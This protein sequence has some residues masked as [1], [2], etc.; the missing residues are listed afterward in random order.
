MSLF[1]SVSHNGS[2]FESNLVLFCL[3]PSECWGM[4]IEGWGWG[5]E[6][7]WSQLLLGGG[8]RLVFASA[9]APSCS[10]VP[11]EGKCLTRYWFCHMPWG[12]SS[13][14]CTDFYS[15]FTCSLVYHTLELLPL[16]VKGFPCRKTAEILSC[17][18]GKMR[19]KMTNRFS[20]KL[21]Q[22]WDKAN[23]PIF[24]NEAD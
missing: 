2:T 24:L 9:S 5:W 12:Q 21:H 19:H 1:F 7:E 20:P 14:L 13:E 18:S 8:G 22:R 4:Q 16:L 11:F 23:S 10:Y 17:W 6:I 3:Y 15:Y